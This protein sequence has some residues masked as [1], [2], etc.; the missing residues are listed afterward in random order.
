MR[1][2]L[3]VGRVGGLAVAFG[4]GI[5]V[6]AGS[7]TAAAAPPASADSSSS[8]V[9]RAGSAHTARARADGTAANIARAPHTRPATSIRV[10]AAGTVI[11]ARKTVT[12]DP[13]APSDLPATLA[14]AIGTRR[15]GLATSSRTAAATANAVTTATTPAVT[16]D[17][18]SGV[19]AIPQTPPLAFLQHVPVLGPQVVTPIVAFIHQIPVLGDVLHPLFGYPVYPGASPTAVQARDVKVVSFDGTQIYVHFM[20]ATGLQAGQQAPTILDGPGLGMPGQTS[21]DGSILDGLLTDALGMP[22]IVSLRDNGYNVVTWDP[23]G[24]YSSGGQLEIDSPDYEARDMSAIIN[25]VATQPEVQLDGDPANLDPRIGMV[26]AS[27]GGGIQLVTAAIDHRVDAIVPTIAWNS[28]TTSL[29]KS[30]SFKSGWGTILVA[31]LVLTLARTNPAIIPA[32]IYG[33]LTGGLSQADQDLLAERGPGLPANLINQITAPTLFIQ[34]TVDTLF[35]LQ[36]AD[37]NALALIGNDVPTKVLW[38]CGGH[39]LC[40]NNLFDGSDG[41]MVEERTLEWLDRYV[42]GDDTVATGPQFEW[43]DQRGQHFS[44]ASYHLTPSDSVVASSTETRTLP[45]VPFLG[46][47]G[48]LGVLPIGSAPAVNALNLTTPAAT[49]TTYVVGAPRLTFTYSGTGIGDHLYAQLVDDS[50]GQVLGNQVTP[51]LVTLDGTER[52]VSVPLEMVAQTLNPGQKVTLQLFGSS[53]AYRAVGAL[54]ALTVSN[55]QLTLPTVDPASIT[56]EVV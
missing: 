46:A 2:G 7:G 6:A 48:L 24:E 15:E 20:P 14:L 37:A 21:L 45:L 10:G 39:G 50:T 33:D 4:I 51:I 29:Y 35:T 30:Q 54:G 13:A 3:H 17:A 26:G 11:R 12:D 31:A 49:A 41:V 9:H 5:A 38:F 43:V 22:S 42:K 23:R 19:L 18:S 36:E 25:W 34:G 1:A 56:A 16:A 44:S 47:G 52:T 8:S 40:T 55:M 53:A 28:L 27:Y 32:S